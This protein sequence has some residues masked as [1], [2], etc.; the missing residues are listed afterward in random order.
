MNTEDLDRKD[1][2]GL[3]FIRDAVFYG[4]KTPT[5]R[6]IAKHM[7]YLSPRSAA[8]LL[9]RLEKNG[10]VQRTPGGNLRLLK[11]VRVESFPERTIGIPL[12]GAV[13][14][15]LPLLAEE[16]IEAIIPVSQSIAKPGAQYFLLRAVGDSMDCAGINDKDI[17]LIRQQPVAENGQKIV[18]L[19]D[20]AATVKEF[21]RKGD[22]VVLMP[23]SNNPSHKPIILAEDFMVQGIVVTALPN[24]ET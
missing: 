13:P 8:L 10:Y 20:D 18:A 23:R 6:A 12:V 19:I 2:K 17:L 9:E 21:Q 15:G 1:L 3:L 11:N 22:H 4:H 14:C 16:N 7:G 24:F 5:L